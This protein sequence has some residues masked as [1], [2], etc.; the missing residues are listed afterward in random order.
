MTFFSVNIAFWLT[1]FYEV[2]I[3]IIFLPGAEFREAFIFYFMTGVLLPLVFIGSAGLG[4][5]FSVIRFRARLNSLSKA[6]VLSISTAMILC[7][8]VLIIVA[9]DHPDIRSLFYH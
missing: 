4:L 9:L 3:A 2:S 7:S 8:V 5:A 1:L 6:L